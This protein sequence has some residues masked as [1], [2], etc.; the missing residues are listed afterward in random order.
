[1]SSLPYLKSIRG[2]S[3]AQVTKKCTYVENNIASLTPGQK[4]EY[5]TCLKSLKLE[6]EGLNNKVCEKYDTLTRNW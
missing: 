2:H 1:M 4:Q 6:L 5:I 3:R